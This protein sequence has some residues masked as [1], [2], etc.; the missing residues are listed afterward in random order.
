MKQKLDHSDGKSGYAF[1]TLWQE[2]TNGVGV[3]CD[4]IVNGLSVTEKT[5]QLRDYYDIQGR[6]NWSENILTKKS[7]NTGMYMF[8]VLCFALLIILVVLATKKKQA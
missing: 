8:G 7:S 2:I 1:N 5:Q 3:M 4:A 6:L